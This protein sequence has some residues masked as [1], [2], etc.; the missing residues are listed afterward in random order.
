[1]IYYLSQ[2]YKD[3]IIEFLK[4]ERRLQLLMYLKYRTYRNKNFPVDFEPTTVRD[5]YM[6]VEKV[7]LIKYAN[8]Y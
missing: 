7:L 1:M 5:M 8:E 3:K 2:Y 6:P 4:I